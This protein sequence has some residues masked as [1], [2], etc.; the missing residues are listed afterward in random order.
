MEVYTAL[1]PRAGSVLL[2]KTTYLSILNN[3]MTEC[4]LGQYLSY[5]VDTC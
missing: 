4:I 2:S 5:K 1:K 3:G